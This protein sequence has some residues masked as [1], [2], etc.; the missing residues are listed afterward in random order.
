M[1]VKQ[2]AF[3][4]YQTNC[5]LIIDDESKDC[6]IVDPCME[7]PTEFQE[8]EKYIADRGLTPKFL[9]L[10]HAHSD[11][12]CGLEAAAKKYALP[13]VTHRDSVP[14]IEMAP[15]LGRMIGFAINDLRTVPTQFVADGEV[16]KLG[17]NDICCLAVPGHC[18]GSMAYYLKE[19]G[20]VITGD[21][22]FRMSIGRTDLPGGDLDILLHSIK[23]NLLTLPPD[24]MVL[25]GHGECSSIREEMLSNPFI[26]MD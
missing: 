26:A 21:A 24:T 6:A 15:N 1:K 8:I 11:H 18:P 19:E 4:H 5:F 14:F 16:M 7:F 23:T 12:I 17:N 13:V 2:F 3:N 25:P 9:L 20:L 10:T 22:L